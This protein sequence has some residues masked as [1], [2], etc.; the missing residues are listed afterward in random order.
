MNASTTAV[1]EL[2]SDRDSLV[3]VLY[4]G[5]TLSVS[6]LCNDAT[7]RARRTALH[8]H[9][10]QAVEEHVASTSRVPGRSAEGTQCA[11]A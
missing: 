3:S 5:C 4:G 8:L 11:F 1:R 6:A 10:A 7:T 2:R 9:K